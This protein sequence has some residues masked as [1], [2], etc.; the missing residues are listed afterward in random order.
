LIRV[1]IGHTNE[2]FEVAFS[3][4]GKRLATASNDD[5]IK[6]WDTATGQQ[7]LTLK[8]HTD[9]VWSVAFS[10]DGRTLASGS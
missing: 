5:T 3:P 10:P 1:F 6:I 2:I 9:E 7:L 4:D 8:D